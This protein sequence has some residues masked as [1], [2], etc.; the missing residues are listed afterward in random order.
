[1]LCVCLLVSS[2][3]PVFGFHEA[4]T[5]VSS[6]AVGLV[7][8]SLPKSCARFSSISHPRRRRQGLVPLL[9]CVR[10]PWSRDSLFATGARL[11]VSRLLGL[12]PSGQL[13]PKRRRRALDFSSGFH[14]RFLVQTPHRR[15][16]HFF[17]F[18]KRI[19]S[20]ANVLRLRRQGCLSVGWL[21]RPS[22]QFP[23]A[24]RILARVAGIRRR[25][26]LDF[27]FALFLS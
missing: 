23:V 17:C 14:F 9:G 15:F 20:R 2:A 21:V 1:V 6:R 25:V 12:Q 3:R 10:E 11:L 22:G 27:W 7:S 26:H 18:P 8:R 5:R 4:S 13:V 16:V 24:P 19:V